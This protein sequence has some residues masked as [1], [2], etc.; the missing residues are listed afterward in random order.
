[1]KISRAYKVTFTERCLQP[2]L[3]AGGCSDENDAREFASAYIKEKSFFN[4]KEI[5][6]IIEYAIFEDVSEEYKNIVKKGKNPTKELF[7]KK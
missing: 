5:D 7:K 1:M 6:S 3:I 4:K 2:I